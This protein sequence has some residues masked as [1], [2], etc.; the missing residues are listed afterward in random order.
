MRNGLGT[1]SETVIID[2]GRRPNLEILRT[3]GDRDARRA[4][5]FACVAIRINPTATVAA[6]SGLRSRASPRRCAA[7]AGHGPPSEWCR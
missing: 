1:V 3:S 2:P 7:G 4:A 6:A 5:E